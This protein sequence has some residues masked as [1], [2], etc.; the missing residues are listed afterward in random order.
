ML[1][2]AKNA[3]DAFITAEPIK[4][5]AAGYNALKTALKCEIYDKGL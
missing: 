3:V 2:M 4:I 1:I 5:L